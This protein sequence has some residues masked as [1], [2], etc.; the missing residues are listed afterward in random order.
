MATPIVSL[1]VRWPLS[2]LAETVTR[3]HVS[4]ACYRRVE[5]IGV[6][7]VVVAELKFRNVE[8]HIFRADFV[9]SADH[10]ALEDAPETLN[11]ICVDGAD[12]VFVGAVAHDLVLRKFAVQRVVSAQVVSGEQAD[13][14]G[15]GFVDEAGEGFAVEAVNDPCHDVP[16]AL[17]SANHGGLPGAG[18]ASA[19][20]T[21]V[22]MLVAGLSADIGFV[23]L[24]DAN[25][26]LELFVLHRSA[27][28]MAHVPSRLVRA[29]AHI[30]MDLPG[31]DAFLA[32]R[33]EVDDAKPLPQI[34]VR[35]LENRADKVRKTVRATLPTVRALPAVFKGFEGIDVRAATA[36]AI[37][38]IGP[39]ACDYVGV[40]GFLIREHCL[41]LRD[42]HL[43]DLL[44]LFPGHGFYSH[45]TLPTQSVEYQYHVPD[46]P[47][48][49]GSSP[50]RSEDCDVSAAETIVKG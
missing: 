8:R 46:V 27:D 14:V 2:S 5:N 3:D 16:L 15:N 18:P 7:A 38:P 31:A 45:P 11:R 9:E 32:G 48:S 21:L 43:H 19:A 33:H 12:N 23:H 10:A 34:D 50:S 13:F 35:V 28:A 25:E 42:R 36:R 24:D 29:K 6:V 37:D 4:A 40:A 47:S 22:P 26:F 17:D 1:S 39:A 44:R 49:Q 30:A 20:V 41:E